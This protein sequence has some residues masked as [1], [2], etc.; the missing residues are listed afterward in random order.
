MVNS[1]RRLAL[2]NPAFGEIVGTGFL[3]MLRHVFSP[4]TKEKCDAV[5]NPWNDDGMAIRF[6]PQNPIAAEPITQ[7]M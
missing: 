7:M 5:M 3:L 4:G 6:H 1:E 2:I